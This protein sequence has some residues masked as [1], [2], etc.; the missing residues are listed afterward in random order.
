MYL[1]SYFINI[2][3]GKMKKDLLYFLLLCYLASIC[4]A[5]EASVGNMSGDITPKVANDA[6]VNSIFYKGAVSINLDKD[7]YRPNDTLLARIKVDNLEDFPIADAFIVFDI[8]S[9]GEEHVYPSQSSD[10]DNVLF[11]QVSSGINLLE[12]AGKTVEFSYK[13]PADIKN[14]TYRLEAYFGTKRTPLVGIPAIFI[15]PEYAAFKV[16]GT[17]VFPAARISRTKTIFVNASG[18]IGVGVDPNTPVNGIVYIQNDGDSTLRDQSLNVLV[19]EWDDSACSVE[20]TLWS[21]RFEVPPL[22]P[23]A[24]EGVAVQFTAPEEP[25][26]YAIRLELKDK[27]G[28]TLSLYRSRIVVMGPTAKIRKLAV[29]RTYL[30]AGENASV[31]VLVA[32]SPDHYSMPE[33][34]NAK[35]SVSVYGRDAGEMV[36]S[37]SYFLPVISMRD[38]GMVSKAF[39]F[40]AS[41]EL[42]GLKVC[43]KVESNAGELYDSFCYTALPVAGD[44]GLMK[45]D[46]SGD[47]ASGS[48]SVNMCSQD[49][50]GEDSSSYAAVILLD[51]KGNVAGTE[52]NVVLDPCGRAKFKVASGS[53][54]LLV[55]DLGSGRQTRY[56][57][58][59]SY[60]EGASGEVCGDG[61]CG[62]GE[63]AGNCCIDCNCPAGERC[64][65]GSC[66]IEQTEDQPA[67]D[68]GIA[69]YYVAAVIIVLLL[70]AVFLYGAR[71]RRN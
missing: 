36:Y 24:V 42:S 14:G 37:D 20:E 52:E 70:I 40:K 22:A 17:G 48:L 50:S 15:A 49:A 3:R 19:C 28:R 30:K 63:N 71:A 5:Q 34:A 41:R 51:G 62:P 10:A 8:V 32:A 68:E 60:P 31:L 64:L 65:S 59:L 39:S 53:Y 38:Q 58:N 12:R 57:V 13:I 69:G 45:V 61:K 35:V 29:T 66:V 18:P 23:K 47:P 2:N 67:K 44:V 27:D 1:F 33:V 9:G 4:A 43:S 25:G 7:T 11:E 46:W 21:K 6:F 16:A 26:A 54:V 56:V 55:N